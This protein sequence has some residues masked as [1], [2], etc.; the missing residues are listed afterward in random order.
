MD[1]TLEELSREITDLWEEHRSVPFP[2]DYGGKDVN[3]ID[4]ALLDADIAGCVTSFINSGNL[5]IYQTAI[6]G[7]SYRHTDFILPILN[8][9]GT[10]Y[11]WRLGR[12][13]ELVLKAVAAKNHAEHLKSEK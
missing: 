7:L 10:E 9:E 5:N 8:E 13:A 3:G 11:F 12:L 2:D 4:F 6:L 1:N